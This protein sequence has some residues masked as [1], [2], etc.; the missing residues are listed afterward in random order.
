MDMDSDITGIFHPGTILI[1]TIGVILTGAITVD[2]TVD[3]MMDTDTLILMKEHGSSVLF[4]KDPDHWYAE[5]AVPPLKETHQL[6]Q[7]EMVNVPHPE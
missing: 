4:R 6:V 3:I 1:G 7:S 2:I 5:Q